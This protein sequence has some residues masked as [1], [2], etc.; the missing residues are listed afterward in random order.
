LSKRFRL[1]T[2]L[3]CLTAALA[4]IAGC[5]GSDSNAPDGPSADANTDPQTVLDSALGS[6]GDPITS[7]VLDLSFDLKSTTSVSANAKVTGPFSSNGDSELPSVD[8][9][10]TAGAQTGSAPLSF[11]GALTM[12]PDGLYIGYGDST[13]QLDDSTFQLLKQSYERSSQLQ[14]SQQDGGSLSQFGID[15][16]NWLTNVRNEGTTDVD[17]TE[18][19]H[20]SGDADVSRIVADLGKVAQGTGQSV[21]STGL[22]QLKNSVKAASIDVYADADNS[23]LRKLDVSLQLADPRSGGTDTLSFSIGIADPN[24]EQDISAP[25]DAKPLEDLLGQIPG[26]SDQLGGIA[27]GATGTSGSAAP[28]APSGGASSSG[29]TEK[30][31]KCVAGAKSASEVTD[32]QKLL[33]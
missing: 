4:L 19:V 12:T 17:G 29:A 2:L 30:Y 13:Y 5:G 10:V 18:T 6:Q 1:L 33:G 11:N 9:D 32:C 28:V 26:L 23:V 25:S 15:P 3:A 7:G 27:G 8:F 21:D 24:S 22:S 31:Y 14:Q 16:A 20:I